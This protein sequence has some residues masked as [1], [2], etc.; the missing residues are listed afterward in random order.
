MPGIR[1]SISASASS[2]TNFAN[3][4]LRILQVFFGITVVV[5]YAVMRSS[6]LSKAERGVRPH[7]TFNL[8]SAKSLT[9]AALIG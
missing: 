2:K 9:S 1:D 4:I 7:S 3:L 6:G 5:F 8:V